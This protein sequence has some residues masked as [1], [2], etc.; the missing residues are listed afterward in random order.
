[1]GHTCGRS[2]GSLAVLRQNSR[3]GMLMT[4]LTSKVGDE[5]VNHELGDLQGGKVFLPLRAS[6]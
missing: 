5:K 3:S 2:A 6:Q 1:M 4:L